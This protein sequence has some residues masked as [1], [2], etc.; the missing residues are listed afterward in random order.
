LQISTADF[1]KRQNGEKNIPSAAAL[2]KKTA[3]GP[4]YHT[5]RAGQT[6]EDIFEKSGASTYGKL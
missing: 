5:R 6:K 3:R 4:R 2:S 1:V